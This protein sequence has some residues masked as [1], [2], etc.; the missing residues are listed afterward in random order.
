VTADVQ[1]F[2]TDT[3]NYG[4]LIKKTDEGQNGQVDYTARQGTAG[5]G[6]RLILVVESPQSDAVP[7]AVQITEPSFPVVFNNAT[8][9][10]GVSYSDGGSGLDLASFVLRV[11]GI[12]VSGCTV[13]AA[14][15]TCTPPPLSAG[16]HTISAEVR[17]HA[18]NLATAGYAFELF[19]GDGPPQ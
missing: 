12:A 17:D 18:G 2:L 7:P 14:A 3:G 19:L 13:G 1:A 11:D 9:T 10:L 4:W 5:N 8:P 16:P 15:A 6:P